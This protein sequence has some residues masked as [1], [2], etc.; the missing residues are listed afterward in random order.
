MAKGKTT[1]KVW[2]YRILVVFD[3]SPETAQDTSLVR[4]PLEEL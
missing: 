3:Y 4:F 1:I 2:G